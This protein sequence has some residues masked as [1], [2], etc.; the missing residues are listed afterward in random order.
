MVGWAVKKSLSEL[1]LSNHEVEV[2]LDGTLVRGSSCAVLWCDLDMTF[3]LAVVT[4][5]LKILSRLYLKL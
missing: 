4:L 2:I 3:Y 1:Y 5:I